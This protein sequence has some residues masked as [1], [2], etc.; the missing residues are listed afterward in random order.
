M[1]LFKQFS[2]KVSVW[3]VRLDVCCRCSV[4]KTDARPATVKLLPYGKEVDG[5]YSNM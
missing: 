1:K 3:G 4:G 5:N 2:F